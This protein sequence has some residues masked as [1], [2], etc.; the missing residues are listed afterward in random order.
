MSQSIHQLETAS[1]DELM[2]VLGATALPVLRRPE[3]ILQD[4]RRGDFWA[5]GPAIQGDEPAFIHEGFERLGGIFLRNWAVELRKA[6]CQNDDLAEK[7]HTEGLRQLDVAVGIITGSLAAAI[8]A[9]A[10]FLGLLTVLGVI[11]AR[12]GIRAFCQM[13]EELDSTKVQIA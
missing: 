11:I 9:L 13:L 3:E 7:L 6:V 12:S 10:P 5:E 2:A 8:P 4:G 1:D